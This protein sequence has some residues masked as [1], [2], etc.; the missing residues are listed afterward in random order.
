[1]DKT[2]LRAIFDEDAELYD[3]SRPGYS[4]QLFTDLIELTG[5]GA[6]SRVLEIGCGTGIATEPVA[7][8]GCE[9]TA[10]ELGADMA[11]VARRRLAG[12]PG[13]TVEIGDFERWPLPAKPFD[14]VFSATAFH[15]I[16]PAIRMRR[17]ADALRPGGALAVIST[18][19][20]AGGTERFFVE[21]QRYYER[22]DP[23]TQPGLRLPPSADIPYERAEFDRSG[24]FGLV[25]FRRY[26]CEQEY[27][28]EQY[29]NLLLTYS[30]HRA[31]EPAARAGLLTGIGD[32]IDH[33]FGGR[34]TKHNMTQLT[35]AP[36]R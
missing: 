20:V 33:E 2:T 35:I 31:L 25:E 18:H 24:R 27:T 11:R 13:V 26:E 5:I 22:F 16:D 8:L 4:A 34:I 9:I 6:G 10:V 7:R 36:V 23:D 1:V 21:T 30:G 19:H 29:L 28:R 15:W 14:L 17:T 12:F 3:R 32:L